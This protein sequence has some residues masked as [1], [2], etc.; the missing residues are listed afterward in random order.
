MSICRL[1]LA[2]KIEHTQLDFVFYTTTFASTIFLFITSL[3][4]SDKISRPLKRNSRDPYFTLLGNFVDQHTGNSTG[5]RWSYGDHRSMS[6]NQ[7]W[8]GRFNGSC[9]GG[10]KR[11]ED[12]AGL[13]RDQH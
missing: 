5:D 7:H 10:S 4:V 11:C 6:W 2:R 8:H 13:W 9:C 12:S 1:R 3:L